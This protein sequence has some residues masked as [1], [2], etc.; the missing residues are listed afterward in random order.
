[1]QNAPGSLIRSLSRNVFGRIAPSLSQST[2]LARLQTLPRR[3]MATLSPPAGKKVPFKHTYHGRDFED[4]YNW[5][6]DDDKK[7]KRKEIM[8]H[9]EQEKAF[10]KAKLSE[11]D[12]LKQELYDEMLGR[13]QV[14]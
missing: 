1:M 5:L 14:R 12:K 10:A 6:R 3:S 8:E 7:E 9:L 4:P 13:I 11:Y 2:R